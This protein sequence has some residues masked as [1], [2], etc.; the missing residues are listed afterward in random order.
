MT[1]AVLTVI[2]ALAV[3]VLRRWN[4][5]AEGRYFDALETAENLPGLSF[6]RKTKNLES[7]SNPPMV[8][9]SGEGAVI[10]TSREGI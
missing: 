8:W 6:S 5:A 2:A 7:A 10:V 1:Y 3:A 4:R 9:I